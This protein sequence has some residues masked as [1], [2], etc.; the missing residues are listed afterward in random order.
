M[1]Y[2]LEKFDEFATLNAELLALPVGRTLGQGVRIPA[3]ILFNQPRKMEFLQRLKSAIDRL[4]KVLTDR[5]ELE[6]LMQG[7]IDY[8]DNPAGFIQRIFRKAGVV[9]ARNANLRMY[10]FSFRITDDEPG[11]LK[12]LLVPFYDEGANLTAIDSMPGVVT[13]EEEA[14]GVNPDRVVNF[15]VGIDPKTVD[16]GKELRIKKRLTE[17][18]CKVVD[19]NGF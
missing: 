18:G 14:K 1:D 3:E 7:N 10:K 15:D 8:H 11:K 6:K 12:E 19:F 17:M 9:G 5:E 2:P 16:A 4:E 13:E